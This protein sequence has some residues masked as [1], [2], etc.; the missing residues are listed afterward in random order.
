MIQLK[1]L[2]RGND[3]LHRFLS[4]SS[5]CGQVSHLASDARLRLAV[6]VKFDEWVLQG[7]VPFWLAVRPK[8]AEQVRHRGGLA[9]FRGSIRQSPILCI[10]IARPFISLIL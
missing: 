3:T 6:E 10:C 9:K 4:G 2:P 8:V 1:P 7:G 5:G